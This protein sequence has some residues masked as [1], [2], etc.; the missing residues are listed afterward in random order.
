[1]CYMLRD[2]LINVCKS[3]DHS[4]A[5]YSAP[6]MSPCLR[7]CVH[8]RPILTQ[9]FV[10][11]PAL[12]TCVHTRPILTQSS[13]RTRVLNPRASLNLCI[14]VGADPRVCPLSPHPTHLSQRTS[15]L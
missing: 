15:F 3:D 4:L 5:Q 8:T 13:A 10:Y 14:P 11:L 12:R 9:S 7:T 2:C 6:T 1:M